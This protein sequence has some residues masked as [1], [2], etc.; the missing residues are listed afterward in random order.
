MTQLLKVGEWI[1]S[2]LPCISVFLL[3]VA[4]IRAR[5]IEALLIDNPITIGGYPSKGITFSPTKRDNLKFLL[6]LVIFGVI[7]LVIILL[8]YVTNSPYFWNIIISWFK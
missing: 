5:I 4:F 1:F 7:I 3:V 8:D 6:G 2:F